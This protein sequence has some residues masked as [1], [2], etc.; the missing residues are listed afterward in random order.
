MRK[1]I[2]F[3]IA[4]SPG[5]AA[6]NYPVA[7]F[8]LCIGVLFYSLVEYLRLTGRAVPLISNVIAKASRRR[9]QGRFVFGPITL[10]LGA[11]FA[12]LI[13]PL[14][15]A[16]IAIYALAFGDGFA[17]LVGKAI[18]RIRPSFL[19]GKSIEGSCACFLAVFI[20]AYGVSGQLSLAVFAAITATLVEVFPLRDFDNIAIPLSVGFVLLLGGAL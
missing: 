12:L 16:G 5:M 14:Q 11:L 10:G 7:I 1:S 15:I 19:F 3:L 17:S 6:V 4:L 8:I 13:F 20:S 2:H 18:G 9:E